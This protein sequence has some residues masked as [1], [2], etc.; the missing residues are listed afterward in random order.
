MKY[1]IMICDYFESI[2]ADSEEDA[3]EKVLER[4]KSGE[5]DFAITAWC[6]E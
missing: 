2:D 4:I 5:I 3:I 1:R 6:E